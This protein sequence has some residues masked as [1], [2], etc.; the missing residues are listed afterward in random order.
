MR[1]HVKR[2]QCKYHI[3][4]M[5]LRQIVI[6]VISILTILSSLY[7]LVNMM[8]TR[9]RRANSAEKSYPA[10]YLDRYAMTFLHTK[11]F[12]RRGAKRKKLLIK[13]RTG[14]QMLSIVTQWAENVFSSFFSSFVLSDSNKPQF[15]VILLWSKRWDR[16]WLN[17]NLL[18]AIASRS[19]RIYSS[20]RPAKLIVVYH[21]FWLW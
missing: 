4:G 12:F 13:S 14:T 16:S 17:E 18:N 6:D 15:D 9:W 10:D 19:R 8:R 7:E 1:I 2:H 21:F 3:H 5:L 20:I 11:L